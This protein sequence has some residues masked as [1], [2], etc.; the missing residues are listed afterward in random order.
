MTKVQSHEMLVLHNIRMEWSK[1]RKKTTKC[2][3]R[4]F[5]YDV[6]TTQCEN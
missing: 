4:I 5:K 6:E 3:K 1:V 2:D